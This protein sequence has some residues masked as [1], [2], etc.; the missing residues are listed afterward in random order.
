[1]YLEN[2][3]LRSQFIY[4]LL[5]HFISPSA[6]LVLTVQWRHVLHFLVGVLHVLSA[7]FGPCC[8]WGRGK[9]VGTQRHFHGTQGGQVP[10]QFAILQRRGDRWTIKIRQ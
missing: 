10:G 9:G 7:S 1:M 5:I 8:P 6:T 3:Y 2:T 4:F